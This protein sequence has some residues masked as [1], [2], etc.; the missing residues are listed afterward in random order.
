MEHELLISK[1]PAFLL[2]VI[3]ALVYATD[4]KSKSLAGLI[5]GASFAFIGLFMYVHNLI[6]MGN[7]WSIKVEKKTKVVEK[8]FFKYIRHPLYAGCLLMCLGGIIVSMNIYLVI[9]FVFV[10]LPFVYFRAK[11]EENILSKSLKGYKDYM[12]KTKMFIPF[13]F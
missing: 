3:N 11:L 12:K 8:G 9:L 4:Y 6:V 10:N 13:I 5:I 7:V 2:V 1:Y